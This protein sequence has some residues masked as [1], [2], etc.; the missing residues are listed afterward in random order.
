MRLIPAVLGILGAT[1]V[2]ALAGAQ[3]A[4]AQ[5]PAP[6]SAY[7]S[8][9][10]ISASPTTQ[11]SLRGRP[12]SELGRIVVQGSRSG[13]HTG[14][15]RAHSD[16]QGASWLP[17][18]RF[19]QGERVTV[20]TGLRVRGARQ[21]DFSFRVARLAGNVIVPKPPV[22]V[23]KLLQ[24]T[25]EPGKTR[26]FRT[27]PDLKPPVVTVSPGS[28]A[29]APGHLFLSPKAKNDTKQAGPMISDNLGRPI[30]FH[31]LPGIRAATDFRAQTFKGQPVLTYWQGTSSFGIGTGE[32]VMLDQAYRPIRRIRAP[33]GFKPDL[34][35]FRITPRD[36]AILISYPL[37]Q[38]D[39]RSVG[40]RKRGVLV[41]SVLQEVDLDTGLV[42]FEWHSVGRIA[43]A[44]AIF[45]PMNPRAPWDYVHSNSVALDTDGNFLMSARSTWGVYKIDRGTGGIV[46]RLGGKRSTFKLGK[47]VK[48]AWQHDAQRRAD[49]ALTLFDNSAAPATRRASRALA[50]RLDERRR[51]ATLIRGQR[52]PKNYLAATQGNQQTLPG[53][54]LLVGWGSQRFFTEFDSRGRVAWDARTATGYESYRAY[55]MP[56]VGLPR[57]LPKVA[58]IDSPGAGLDVYVSWNGATEVVAWEVLSGLAPRQL[59]PAGS[60]GRRGFETRIHI[61]GRPTWVAVR[62]KDARGNVL[63]TSSAVRVQR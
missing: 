33:N 38:A 49:G 8:P 55:R 36:T 34:H 31:P 21:G 11:I 18:R 60:L 41:D 50:I 42:L 22:A 45:P 19:Q 16:G 6:V 61:G 48:F 28:K 12:R 24:Q 51:T 7:P 62:A 2:A 32:M 47:G 1:G 14:T 57:T 54:G 59:T 37:V 9:G 17:S 27:R 46:W 4:P 53:G 25:G 39:L 56:W 44:E 3:S 5:A 26:R 30:W 15:L 52:H 23:L 43:L 58:G 29:I 35:E 20:G 13:A 10:S 63:A 40:G